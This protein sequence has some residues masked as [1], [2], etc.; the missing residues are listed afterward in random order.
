MLWCPWFWAGSHQQ[1]PLRWGSVSLGPAPCLGA[2]R[3][4]VPKQSLAR[5]QRLKALACLGRCCSLFSA[6]FPRGLSPQTCH[7]AS[8]HGCLLSWTKTF[9]PQGFC[10]WLNHKLFVRLLTKFE[11]DSFH[12][13]KM[14]FS[15]PLGDFFVGG[16]NLAGS[17]LAGFVQCHRGTTVVVWE[18]MGTVP[19]QLSSGVWAHFCKGG[20]RGAAGWCIACLLGGGKSLTPAT[21][22]G[23]RPALFL[24][25][26][27][28]TRLG[29]VA[30]PGTAPPSHPPHLPWEQ[31]LLCPFPASA[32][33]GTSSSPNS[34]TTQPG[35]PLLPAPA[36]A[37]SSSASAALDL[38]GEGNP[39]PAT[40]SPCSDWPATVLCGRENT[41]YL[42]KTANVG[43]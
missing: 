43:R 20:G 14:T 37:R 33:A 26:L 2:G 13:L 39:G 8:G 17:N 34:G 42:L 30:G 27:L 41:S 23:P 11:N 12:K 1:D 28:G 4:D 40:A 9:L 22:E 21:L 15:V 29:L 3:R 35:L 24:Q 32:G 5:R 18:K 19:L 36:L 6:R 25:L 31:T 10:S 7:L 16:S 38:P